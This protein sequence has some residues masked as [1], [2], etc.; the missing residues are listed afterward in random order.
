[1]DTYTRD[2]GRVV[3]CT[4]H[5]RRAKFIRVFDLVGARDGGDEVH[6]SGVAWDGGAFGGHVGKVAA[7]GVGV[8][9]CHDCCF[10]SGSI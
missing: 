2:V 3:R 10:Y 4:L 1:M 6:L 7:L 8:R 9:G 5:I